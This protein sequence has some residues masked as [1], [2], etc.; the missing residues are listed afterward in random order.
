MTQFEADEEEKRRPMPLTLQSRRMLAGDLGMDPEASAIL[1]RHSFLEKGVAD[2]VDEGCLDSAFRLLARMLSPAKSMLWAVICHD[3]GNP[4]QAD[5]SLPVEVARTALLAFARDPGVQ[6]KGAAETAGQ[7][8]GATEPLGLAASALSF[9]QDEKSILAPGGKLPENGLF[10]DLV[11]RSVLLMALGTP[12]GERVRATKGR[13]LA[14]K[15][16]SLALFRKP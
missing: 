7:A 9:L 14:A 13:V 10:G 5:G 12:G 8:L 16:V 1:E 4:P 15:G 11:G 3:E 2:L 6:T